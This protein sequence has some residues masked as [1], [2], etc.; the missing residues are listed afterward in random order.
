MEI[1]NVGP[2]IG[3]VWECDAEPALR[4]TNKEE[5]KEGEESPKSHCGT[6]AHNND[7][8]DL[9][10]ARV[11]VAKAYET[12]FIATDEYLANRH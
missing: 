8:K 3:L 9:E 4:Q 12:T 11:M 6:T 1:S 2:K 7:L 10:N 5:E